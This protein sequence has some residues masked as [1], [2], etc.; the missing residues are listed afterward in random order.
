MT[1]MTGN[2]KGQLERLRKRQIIR[3]K[4]VSGIEDRLMVTGMDIGDRRKEGLIPEMREQG[5]GKERSVPA[6]IVARQGTSGHSAEQGRMAGIKGSSGIVCSFVIG[7]LF[8]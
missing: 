8:K 2:G 7:V 5:R 3:E 4:A 6:I 1:R